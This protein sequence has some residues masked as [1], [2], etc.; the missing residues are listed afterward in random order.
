MIVILAAWPFYASKV[1]P[2][3]AATIRDELQDA[4]PLEIICIADRVRF[5]LFRM[6]GYC[7]VDA[8]MASQALRAFSRA[9]QQTSRCG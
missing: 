2:D 5:T 1:G 4:T 6:M 3:A 8:D 7:G 9:Y